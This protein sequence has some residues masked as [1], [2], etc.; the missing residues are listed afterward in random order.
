[1]RAYSYDLRQRILH[2]VDQ[3]KSRIEI[4]QAFD[5]SQATIKRYLKL[6]RE[7]GDVKP[8]AIPGRPAIEQSPPYLQGSSHNSMLTLM[9]RLRNIVT[10][11]KAQRRIQVSTAT[12]DPDTLWDA[13][14]L[15][16]R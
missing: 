15:L 9:Q 14:A 16:S 2:A 12:I 3:G 1:M 4:I 10:S 13:L 8:K 7:T 11:G 6:R 5:V